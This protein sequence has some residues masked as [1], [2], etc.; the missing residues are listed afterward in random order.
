MKSLREWV[1]DAINEAAACTETEVRD[2]TG[3]VLAIIAADRAELL[4]FVKQV[5]LGLR[6]HDVACCRC[7]WCKCVERA[8]AI[9][10]IWEV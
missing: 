2:I 9:L 3:A 7:D 1:A 8:R 10:A 4:A 6:S 5:S